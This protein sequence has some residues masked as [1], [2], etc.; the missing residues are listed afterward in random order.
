MST[1]LLFFSRPQT[2]LHM[3]RGKHSL[4]LNL[5]SASAFLGK[6]RQAACLG[7]QQQISRNIHSSE[8]TLTSKPGL[9]AGAGISRSTGD[10]VEL[11]K[12]PVPLGVPWQSPR[13]LGWP[14]GAAEGGQRSP[15]CSSDA[16]LWWPGWDELGCRKSAAEKGALWTFLAEVMVWVWCAMKVENGARVWWR[17]G[18]AKP[19]GKSCSCVG[20]GSWALLPL[21]QQLLNCR[22][23][24]Q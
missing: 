19:F 5:H 24:G 20:S 11:F 9:Q 4:F 3:E 12:A 14:Q 22:Q 2:I 7:K 13:G 16:A 17:A 10:G 1:V 8:H 6:L 18:G 21:A 15:W 23:D